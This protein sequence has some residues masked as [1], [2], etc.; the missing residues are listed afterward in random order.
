MHLPAKQII[1]EAWEFTQN[2]K[3]IIVWY[4]L[5]PS[6]LTTLAGI[7]YLIYQ[8][9]AIIS[10]RLFENWDHSFL[11]LLIS[12]VLNIVKS[13]FSVTLPF[14]I[15]AIIIA[16]LY[17]IIPSFCEGAI[18]QLIAR[19]RNAQP[20][21]LRHGVRY[22]LLSFLPLF[23]YS[24][25]VK[26]FSVVSLLFWFLFIARNLGWGAV[27]AFSPIFI[28]FGIAAIILTLLFTYSEFFIVIDSSNIINSMS[29]SSTLVVTHLEETLLLSILMIII[30]VRILIQIIFVLLIPAAMM[31]IAY[32]VTASTVPELAIWASGIV[33]IILLYIASYLNGTIHV[34][35]AAVWTFTFLELTGEGLVSARE[36]G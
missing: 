29:K 5:P 1:G 25:V 36:K 11:F 19:K 30:S 15:A 2:N 31:G 23:E 27:S 22:G 24:F 8:Y 34:F 6:L 4:A 3:N 7:L 9:Y 17:F 28:I 10:S 20:V 12:N 33:G 14:L 32:F 26:T 18:I 35:A 13:N 21:K 16:I